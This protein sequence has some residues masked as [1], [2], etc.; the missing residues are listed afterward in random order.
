MEARPAL[1]RGGR[2]GG[3]RTRR[4]RRVVRGARRVRAERGGPPRGAREPR[5]RAGPALPPRREPLSF[6]FLFYYRGIP[7]D[8]LGPVRIPRGAPGFLKGF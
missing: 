5:L 8:L 1:P 2:L 3:A 4:P 6:F 7:Q